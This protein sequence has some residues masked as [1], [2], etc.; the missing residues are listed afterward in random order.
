MVF[1]ILHFYILHK[2][3]LSFFNCCLLHVW[4]SSALIGLVLTLGLL[5]LQ[6]KKGVGSELTMLRAN[7]SYK[8][9]SQNQ[10]AG[11]SQGESCISFTCRLNDRYRSGS[12]VIRHNADVFVCFFALFGDFFF[13]PVIIYSARVRCSKCPNV[14]PVTPSGC[15]SVCV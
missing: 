13:G 9:I 8:N 2:Q 3:F 5:A 10:K 7:T 11:T 4:E 14:V 1:S 15:V 6:Q 12:H